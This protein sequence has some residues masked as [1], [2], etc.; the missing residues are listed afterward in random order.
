MKL[1][2]G[3]YMVSRPKLSGSVTHY[4]ILMKRRNG[5]VRVFQL[6]PDGCRILPIE[7]FAAGGKVTIHSKIPSSEVRAALRRA[8]RLVKDGT[9]YNVL[10][11]NCEHAA[12]WI[13]EGKKESGQAGRGAAL[14]F[15]LLGL[16]FLK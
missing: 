14:G 5:R 13:A 4:G 1:S 6:G 3:L 15:L 9:R 7:K 11:K 10:T 12:R 8:E 2:P 16:G